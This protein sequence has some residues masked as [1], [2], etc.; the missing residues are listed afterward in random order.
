MGNTNNIFDMINNAPRQSYIDIN[1][2]LKLDTDLL[3]SASMIDG[4]NEKLKELDK[5]VQ[6]MSDLVKNQKGEKII[7]QQTNLTDS[8]E[9]ESIRLDEQK[10]S[11][12]IAKISQGRLITLNENNI[13]RQGEYLKITI[14]CLFEVV[15]ITVMT[16]L[17]IPMAI[18]LT[19]TIITGSLVAIYCLTIYTSII[20][21]DNIYFDEL[22]NE[23]PILASQN[24]VASNKIDASGNSI[25]NIDASG[26]LIGNIDASGNL[27]HNLGA[28]LKKNIDASG[29]L[30]NAN[31]CSGNSCCSTSTMWDPKVEKCV[32]LIDGFST[33]DT[34]YDDNMIVEKKSISIKKNKIDGI[35]PFQMSEFEKYSKI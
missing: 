19:L 11:I 29:N 23:A 20:S 4:N 16:M 24:K 33:I 28:L 17:K 22:S 25:G 14:L 1:D 3:Q 7:L 27:L 8:V 2:V 21:R 5:K 12:E 35:I 31:S 34:A 9:K 13:K 6:K 30:I 26:N 15:F 10:S 18:Y 32:K